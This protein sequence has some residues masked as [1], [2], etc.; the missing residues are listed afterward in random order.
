MKD[1]P[2]SIIKRTIKSKFIVTAAKVW[3]SIK[4]D[5]DLA[6]A[7]LERFDSATETKDYRCFRETYI[8]YES[9]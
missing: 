7:S 8:P 5:K 1:L 2:N 4:S 6:R 3:A 9:N